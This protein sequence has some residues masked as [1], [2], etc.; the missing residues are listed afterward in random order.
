MSR[1]DGSDAVYHVELR[2][3]PHNLCRFN[4]GEQELLAI[5][6][7]WVRGQWIEVGERKWSAYQA[8]LTVIEGPR[9]PLERLSMGRGWRVAE[10]EGRDVT[11]ALV[12]AAEAARTPQ[13][14]V[15][16]SASYAVDAEHEAHERPGLGPA[17]PA[18]EL[19]AD[20]LG[21]ELLAVLGAGRAPLRRAWELAGERCPLY[22]ASEALELA[23]RAIVSLLRS[24]LIVVTPTERPEAQGPLS[25]EELRSLLRAIESWDGPGQS[26]AGAWMHRT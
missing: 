16:A 24:G 6:E 11:G 9:I 7:P 12:R 5:V 4:L 8:R 22:G 14:T 19:V 15:G 3:F 25:E 10:R 1:S 23:E 18:E 26:A 13:A 2:Q 17:A 20:S 21:L